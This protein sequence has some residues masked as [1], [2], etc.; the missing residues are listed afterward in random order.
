MS[1]RE[2]LKNSILQIKEH[3]LEQ[4]E[5]LIKLGLYMALQTIKDNIIEE[6][7]LKELLLEED[8]E[9]YL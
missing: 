6:D 1:D 5:D 7:L 8:L 4:D 9:K 2:I 3:L